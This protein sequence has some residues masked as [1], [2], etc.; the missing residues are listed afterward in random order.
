MSI[1]CPSE[2][3]KEIVSY[4]SLELWGIDQDWQY[5]P[6]YRQHVGGI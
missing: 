2:D 3:V 6:E 5:E 1:K 4:V